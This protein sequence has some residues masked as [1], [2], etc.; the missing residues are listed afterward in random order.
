MRRGAEM[1][2][3]V[4]VEYSKL[5]NVNY[6]PCGLIIHPDAPWLGA[7][8]DGVVFDPTKYPQFGLVEIKCPKVKNIVDCKYLQ[9]DNGFLTL[10]KSHA[11]YW[12]VQ[13]QLLV[14][15]M[16]WCDFM[17]W[18]QEDYFVQRI[19]SDTSMHKVIIE[20]VD[21]FYFYTYMHK[22]L[23][24][25]HLKSLVPKHNNSILI[26]LS[27]KVFSL[28]R[29]W[30]DENHYFLFQTFTQ[31]LMVIKTL[32]ILIYILIL[33]DYKNGLFSSQNAINPSI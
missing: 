12:Q 7:S 30:Q 27:K 2:S 4:T 14:S 26:N 23:S 3:K 33:K 8:P 5:T 29:K 31:Y 1:E 25:K 21:Y 6:S 11:Y 20:K 32:K 17:V 18:A 9:M 19:H 24:M 16:Q 13:G 15:E 22:Y 10:K 28:P